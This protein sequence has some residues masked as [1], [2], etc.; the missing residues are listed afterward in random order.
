MKRLDLINKIGT[1]ELRGKVVSNA[2]IDANGAAFLKGASELTFVGRATL[3]ATYISESER[4]QPVHTPVAFDIV[5][6]PVSEYIVDADTKAI[7]APIKATELVT[8]CME[9]RISRSLCI[10]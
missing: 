4:D 10:M 5:G 9:L 1:H 2:E 6:F 3:E 7:I 8:K